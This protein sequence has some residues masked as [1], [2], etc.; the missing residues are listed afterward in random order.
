MGR[1]K[2]SEWPSST[3]VGPWAPN[4]LETVMKDDSEEHACAM[5]S[6][7]DTA[8]SKMLRIM[9]GSSSNQPINHSSLRSKALAGVENDLRYV[10]LSNKKNGYNSRVGSALPKSH[11]Y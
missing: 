7:I 2:A 4:E 11:A 10:P 1:V 3:V 8:M 5:Q 6:K 9:L